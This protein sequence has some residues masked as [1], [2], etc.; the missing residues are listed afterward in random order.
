MDETAISAW[1]E[2]TGR[3]ALSAP[4]Q[5]G[6]LSVST[7][8]APIP[9]TPESRQRFAK[10]LAPALTLVAPVGMKD[11]D[12]RDWYA[13]AWRALSHLPGDA[14][15]KA[16][17]QVLGR[18]DHPA[19]IVQAILDAA[20]PD[21]DWRYRM[22][23]GTPRPHSALPAPGDERPTEDEADAICKRYG[24]GRYAKTPA[25]SKRDPSQPTELTGGSDRPGKVPTRED[26]IRMG[27]DPAVLDRMDSNRQAKAA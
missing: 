21:M 16:A 20:K 6:R 19:K 24:V 18:V 26:Y 8:T 5:S 23:E 4:Q 14:I 11:G 7:D 13:A 12:R 2:T 1:N 9:D 3:G 10:A 27:V 25:P 22:R 15:E 17:Q